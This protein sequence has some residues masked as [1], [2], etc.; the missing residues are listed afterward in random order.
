MNFFV[1]ACLVVL[2][3][4]LATPV[5]ERAKLQRSLAAA[6]PLLTHDAKPGLAS[7]VRI[8]GQVAPIKSLVAPF[9]GRACT[10]Y[11][12]RVD[13]VLV[14]ANA[15]EWIHEADGTP[16]LLRDATGVALV[17]PLHARVAVTPLVSYSATLDNPDARE[18]AF[19]AARNLAARGAFFNKTLRYT[20]IIIAPDAQVTVLGIPTQEIDPDA[21]ARVADYRDLAPTRVRL[22]G[23]PEA[24]LLITD[25][26]GRIPDCLD[27]APPAPAGL[28]SGTQRGV[29]ALQEPAGRAEREDR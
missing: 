2:V 17:D 21:A 5:S 16:F 27:R 20:E 9:S 10:Y 8:T 24:P 6:P 28:R 19:L 13:E 12:V 4:W 22:S 11:E 25:R 3:K 23:R 18:A 26:P 29:R 7:P 1:F 14:G 15:V